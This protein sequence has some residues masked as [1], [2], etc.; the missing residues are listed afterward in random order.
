MINDV[1]TYFK[2]LPDKISNAIN[3]AIDRVATWGSNMITKAKNAGNKFVTAIVDYFK[4]LPSKISSWLSNALQKV[5]AWATNL[6]NK[7]K[8]AGKKL[9]DSIINKAK[10]IPTKIKS[11]GTDIVKGLWN[12]INGKVDWLVKK[13]KGFCKNSLDAIKNFF[14][15]HSPS[16]V[17]EKEV[18]EQIANGMIKG[19]DNKKENAKKSAKQLAELYVTAGKTKVNEMK[20]VNEMSLADEVVFWETVLNHCRKGSN[21]YNTATQNF[22]VA[23]QA[24]N[25]ELTKLN[26]K[27]EADVHEIQEK[28]TK[29]IQ[30]VTDAYNQAVE[31]RQRQIMSSMGLFDMFSASE[32]IGKDELTSNLKSQVTALREWDNVLDALSNRNGVNVDFIGE[33]ESM[34]VSSLNTLKQIN[35]MTDSELSAYVKLYDEKKA[36]A[37]ERSKTEHEAL[38]IESDK[39]IAELIADADKKLTELKELYDTELKALGII[40]NKDAKEVGRN[41]VQGMINGIN[42]KIAALRAKMRELAS[43]TVSTAQA[44]LGIHS[45]SR[46]FAENVGKWIPEG[47]AQGIVNNSGVASD[48]VQSVTND[49]LNGATVGR[50]LTN[51]FTAPAVN[52]TG[53]ESVLS[54]LDGIY[55]RLN[56]M[57]IVLDTGT[58]VGETIDKIDAGL[59]NKQLLSARGV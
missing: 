51:T 1:V 26:T 6:A 13:I 52:V 44:E 16:V 42:S 55:E 36:I 22:K 17:M 56:R 39:Q 4:Q 35:A 3:G 58:L 34:G 23:K 8:E 10:E 14:G 46:V 25:D 9:L 53:N 47:I 12:G 24:L 7:G 29:D 32:G 43:I 5:G 41:V 33:L 20:K 49:M 40:A 18:G 15:I 50:K 48:A 59:A 2:G 38:K 54:K 19:I 11:V 31:A 37:L 27:Y 30:A 45:P 57:Q 28:L 21:A